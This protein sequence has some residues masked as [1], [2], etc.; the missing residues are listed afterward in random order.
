MGLYLLQL[1]T[2]LPY[3]PAL[4]LL[5]INPTEMTTCVHKKLHTIY[6][7]RKQNWETRNVYPHWVQMG[8]ES[9]IYSYTRMRTVTW[10]NST[11]YFIV[12]MLRSLKSGRF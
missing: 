12:C 4:P 10:V 6:I 5:G 3:D 2:L 8:T 11:D 1:K 9:V 7:H